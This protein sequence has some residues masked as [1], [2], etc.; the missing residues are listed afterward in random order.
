MTDLLTIKLHSADVNT[1]DPMPAVHYFHQ[2]RHRRPLYSDKKKAAADVH[3]PADEIMHE[4]GED[5]SEDE[6]MP[7]VTDM[8]NSDYGSELSDYESELSDVDIEHIAN[9]SEDM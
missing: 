5:H 7:A 8:Y 3:Q 9:E 6:A 4:V 2:G 1:F